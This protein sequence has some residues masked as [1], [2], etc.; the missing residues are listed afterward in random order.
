LVICFIQAVSLRIR[1]IETC[2]YVSKFFE[3]IV[4]TRLQ[5]FM[6]MKTWCQ[7]HSPHTVLSSILRLHL[8]K[9]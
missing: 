3:R 8:P 4:Q 1:D 2:G 5:A 9:C 6:D 7:R